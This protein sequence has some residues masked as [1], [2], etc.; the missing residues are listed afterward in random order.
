MSLK[1]H[2]AIAVVV[3]AGAVLG[4]AAHAPAASTPVTLRGTVG[5]GFTINVTLAGKKVTQ[6]NRGVRYRLVV[7]DRS[8]IHDFHLTGP[9]LDRV[10]TTVEFTGTKSL[11]F[12]ARKGSY[13]YVCDPHSAFMHGGFRV[14]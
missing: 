10:I 3:A 9:G 7:A 12:T 1:L 13:R 2:T 14:V 5:P 4:L 8:S 6:L 11:V